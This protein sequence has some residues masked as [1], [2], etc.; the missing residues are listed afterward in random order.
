MGGKVGEWD[1]Y[2]NDPTSA[3]A[4]TTANALSHRNEEYFDPSKNF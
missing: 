3:P 4:A 2:K 1:T